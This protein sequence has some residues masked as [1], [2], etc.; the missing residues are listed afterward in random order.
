MEISCAQFDCEPR[1]GVGLPLFGRGH[2]DAERGR[3]LVEVHADEVTQLRQLGFARIE[4]GEFLQR[5]VHGEQLAVIRHGRKDF[6]FIQVNH[7]DSR[8]PFRSHPAPGA[9][10]ENAERR[11]R[12]SAATLR[13][14]ERWAGAGDRRQQFPCGCDVALLY[15]VEDVSDV[16]NPAR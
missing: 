13:E 6:D 3:R 8:A 7:R 16:V 14:R 4:D 11:C 15:A 12:P 1:P 2:G 5:F 9:L 10:N